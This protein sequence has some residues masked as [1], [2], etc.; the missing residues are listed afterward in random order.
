VRE[1]L[2]LDSVSKNYSKR[3]V[4]YKA[5][6][7]WN[8]LPSSIKEFSSVRY[9]SNKLKEFL[10]VVDIDSILMYDCGRVRSFVFYIGLYVLPCEKFCLSM[11]CLS[12]FSC[13]SFLVCLFLSVCLSSYSAL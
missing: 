11:S 12:V 4:S 9:F 6:K 5:S 13:L 2:H 3:T 7:I 8:Q 10:Q 1:N